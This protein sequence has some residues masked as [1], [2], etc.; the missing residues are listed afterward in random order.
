MLLA[1]GPG[2]S[3]FLTGLS[4]R[5]ARYR[6]VEPLTSCYARTVLAGLSPPQTGLR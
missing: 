2:L 3:D 1:H 5:A 6:T 4:E